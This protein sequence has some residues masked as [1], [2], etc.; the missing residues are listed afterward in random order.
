[1]PDTRRAAAFSL[2]MMLFAAS[3]LPSSSAE[4]SE[5]RGEGIAKGLCSR[6]HAIGRSGNSPHSAAPRFRDLDHRTNLS[7]L[8]Q[9]I[10]E[11]LLSGHEDMPM[12]R[13]DRDDAEAMVAYIRS[14]QGR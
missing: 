8:S 14:I 13:F 11:G 9:R 3:A 4:T 6:C 10:R 5:Q 1:M 2:A 12:V 7:K